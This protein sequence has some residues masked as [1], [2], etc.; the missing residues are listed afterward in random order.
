MTKEE[1]WFKR[2]LSPDDNDSNI[3]YT[4]KIILAVALFPLMMIYDLLTN[5]D[6]DGQKRENVK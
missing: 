1:G 4:T 2:N 5:R 6:M 3:V